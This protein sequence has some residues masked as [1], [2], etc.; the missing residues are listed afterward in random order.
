[1][2]RGENFVE[3]DK[4]LVINFIRMANYFLKVMQVEADAGKLD[5]LLFDEWF[6]DLLIEPVS[7]GA[8]QDAIVP[9]FIAF[10]EFMIAEE[11]PLE[12]CGIKN[13]PLVYIADNKVLDLLIITNVAFR[14]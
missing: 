8:Y 13:I 3:V 1:M 2:G 10:Y 7:V 5:Q 11:K 12:I 6:G 4:F 14:M 9:V